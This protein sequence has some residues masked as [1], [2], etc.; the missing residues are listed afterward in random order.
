MLKENI[1]IPINEIIIWKANISKKLNMKF[2][3]R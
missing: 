1:N 3:K 2:P